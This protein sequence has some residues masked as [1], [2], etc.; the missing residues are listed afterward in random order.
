MPNI[1]KILIFLCLI[2]ISP[3]AGAEEQIVISVPGPRN[4]S[5]LPVDLMQKLVFDRAEGV[6]LQLLHTGGGAV[7]L[8]HLI[9][10]NADFAVA[11]LPAAMSMR[12][13][14]MDAVTVAAVDDASFCADGA[15]L[16]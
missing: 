10:R 3:W 15:C 1:S 6:N 8:D 13:N 4:I 12:A 2:S 11:G 16:A 7:A 5:Y 9:K 14:G